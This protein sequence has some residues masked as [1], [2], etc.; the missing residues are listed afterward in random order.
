[1]DFWKYTEGG[2]DLFNDMAGSE[3]DEAIELPGTG[4]VFYQSPFVTQTPNLHSSST[5]YRTYIYGHEA[6]IATFAAVPGDTNVESADYRTIKVKLVRN[7]EESAFDPTATIGNL[8]SYRFHVGF[9]LVPDTTMRLRLIDS[10]SA[11]S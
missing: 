1:V 6:V 3:Q 9:S 8:A 11:Y 4:I 5:G 2:Q 7:L 10:V